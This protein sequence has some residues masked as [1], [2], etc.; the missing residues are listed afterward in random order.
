MTVYIVRLG[1]DAYLFSCL[2]RG[3]HNFCESLSIFFAGLWIGLVQFCLVARLTTAF[4]VVV[5]VV[6]LS[7]SQLC[8]IYSLA[9]AQSRR[10][11]P[12]PAC[13]QGVVVDAE[14]INP[15]PKSAT[16]VASESGKRAVT[17]ELICL[18]ELR[19]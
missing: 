12:P 1:S 15:P 2:S 13:E 7:N 8:K 10:P 17:A 11:P 5:L 16:N 9:V 14:T 18:Y 6:E 3:M 4:I 19:W